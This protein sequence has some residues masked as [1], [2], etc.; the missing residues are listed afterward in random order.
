MNARISE[1]ITEIKEYLQNLSEA[2]PNNIEEYQNNWKT[3]AICERLCE[4]VAESSVDLAFLVFKEELCKDKNIPIP[5]NDSEVFNIL[6]D[7]GIITLELCKKLIELK[8]MRNWLAHEYGKID[9]AKIFE[10]ISSELE[11]DIREFIDKIETIETLEEK[12]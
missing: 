6:K 5:K 1:K 8:G 2:T 11:K 4:K 9:D 3:K 12:K 7:K 10:A